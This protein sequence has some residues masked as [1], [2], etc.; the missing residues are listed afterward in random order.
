MSTRRFIGVF[1][2]LD[3]PPVWIYGNAGGVAALI[4]FADG[5]IFIPSNDVGWQVLPN[6]YLTYGTIGKEYATTDTVIMPGTNVEGQ[7]LAMALAA[8]GKVNSTL[9]GTF[10]SPTVFGGATN[11]MFKISGVNQFASLPTGLVG[12]FFGT[13]TAGKRLVAAGVF[14][15]YVLAGIPTPGGPFA[16]IDADTGI[17]DPTFVGQTLVPNSGYVSAGVL[18][19]PKLFSDGTNLLGIYA[20]GTTGDSDTAN[21]ETQYIYSFPTGLPA[22]AG[23]LSAINLGV[24]SLT[25]PLMTY[26]GANFN[27]PFFINTDGT[28]GAAFASG[29]WSIASPAAIGGGLFQQD[30]ILTRPDNDPAQSGTRAQFTLAVGISQTGSNFTISTAVSVSP[31]IISPPFNYAIEGGSLFDSFN[32][33]ISTVAD[34]ANAV[35]SI[36]PDCTLISSS[37]SVGPTGISAV[38]NFSLPANATYP[39]QAES[40]Y[41]WFGSGRLMQTGA[42]VGTGKRDYISL[43]AS[44][45]SNPIYFLAPGA[46]GTRKSSALAYNSG[47]VCYVISYVGPGGNLAWLVK[48]PGSITINISLAFTIGDSDQ[49]VINAPQFNG[50]FVDCPVS[51]IPFKSGFA[52]CLPYDPIYGS[53]AMPGAPLQYSFSPAVSGATT[54]LLNGPIIVIDLFGTPDASFDSAL[55]SNFFA[56][57]RTDGVRFG[58]QTLATKGGTS[59]SLYFG[60]FYVPGLFNLAGTNQAPHSNLGDLVTAP[61]WSPLSIPG[62]GFTFNGAFGHQKGPGLEV[63]CAC[64]TSGGIVLP[65]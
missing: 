52:I 1:P 60:S 26:G 28:A 35:A 64:D 63:L 18:L 56:L 32:G 39:L 4:I 41:G 47:K 29:R 55:F 10:Y 27:G 45:G 14:A 51:V 17:I 33:T 48:I 9:L 7:A 50:D 54:T 11:A 15:G 42:G 53:G 8:N 58:S 30:S 2:K 36:F 44:D 49:G 40:N 25:P 24:G 5:T 57:A 19:P 22:G 37:G 43:C 62:A 65:P 59:G 31:T 21:V 6:I 12:A 61:T 13:P 20:F 34:M 38:I 23:T 46:S 3:T 16:A